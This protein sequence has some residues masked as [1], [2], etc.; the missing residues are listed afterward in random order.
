M[1]SE[2][3]IL[4]FLH[5]RMGNQRRVVVLWGGVLLLGSF[6]EEGFEQGN[7]EKGLLGLGTMGVNMFK[8]RVKDLQPGVE[9]YQK[10]LNISKPRTHDEDLS[11]RTPYTTL[12]DPQGVIYE[13]KLNRK[14]LMRSDELY[15]F[16]DG[17]KVDEKLGKVRWW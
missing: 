13:D 9:S 5:R 4:V 15:K 11:R 1:P 10:K 6:M 14:R 3:F 8:K 16:S 12:L 2:P 17:K 7:G